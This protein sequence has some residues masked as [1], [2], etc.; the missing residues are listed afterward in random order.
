MTTIPEQYDPIHF[1]NLTSGEQEMIQTV[2]SEGGYGTCEAPT[3][4][5]DFLQRV[6]DVYA[7]QSESFNKDE[8]ERLY[9]EHEGIYYRLRVRNLDVVIFE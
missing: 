6:Y 5:A 4:F 7:R 1:E 9:L 8:E 2:L 3:P